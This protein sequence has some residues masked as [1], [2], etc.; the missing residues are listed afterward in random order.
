MAEITTFSP[1]GQNGTYFSITASSGSGPIF[2]QIQ[3]PGTLQWIGLGQGTRMAGANMFVLY[4][5][6]GDNVTLSPRSGLG[7]SMPESNPEAQVTVLEGTGIENG[8]MTANVRCDNCM[9]F[10][11]DMSASNWIWAYKGGDPINSQN[12]SERILMH[13]NYGRTKID[14]GHALSKSDNPFLGYD[15]SRNATGRRGSGGGSAMLIAHGFL[16]AFAFVLL[17]PTFA[18]LV[19]LPIPI[20]VAKVHAPLQIFTLAVAVAGMGLGLRLWV[21]GGVSGPDVHH[22]LGIIVVAS[23]VLFQ[24]AMGWLQHMHFRKTGGKGGFAYAH[25]WLGRIM[26]LLGIIN[27]GLG[28]RLAGIGSPGTPKSAMIAYSVIAGVMGLAYLLMHLVMALKGGKNESPMQQVKTHPSGENA[29][30]G[31]KV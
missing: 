19:P 28:F 27:G 12:T 2:F 6:S 29:E 25:R 3:A 14:L 11:N 22:V 8:T 10:V 13:D 1:G 23:L 9:G 17:F 18:I 21:L 16:M 31:P 15:A 20:S 30:I 7:H 5:S 26:I 4:S 24:P